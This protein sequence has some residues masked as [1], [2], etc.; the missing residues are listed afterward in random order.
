MRINLGAGSEPTEGWVN[1]DWID[2][3]GIDKV[4]NLLEFPWPFEDGETEEILARDV[5]EHM[6]LFNKENQS[7]PIKFIEEC[8]RIL[9]VGGKLTIQVP[10]WK[11]P[12]LWIDPTHVRGYD[13]KS[14]DYFD[15]EKDYGKWYGYYSPKKFKVNALQLYFNDERNP[16]VKY[17]GNIIFEMVKI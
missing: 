7:V 15:P 14:F 3:P 16:T 6:P 5:L 2:Q 17:K 9:E 10:H 11:S 1:V 13:I 4:H 8:H 12:R